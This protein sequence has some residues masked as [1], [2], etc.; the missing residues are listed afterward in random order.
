MRLLHSASRTH[1][2]FDD[3]SLVSC[4]GLVPVM[5]LAQSCGLHELL[6]GLVR[7][8]TSVGS[9][10]AGKI[11]SIVAIQ[12]RVRGSSAGC[13]CSRAHWRHGT[14]GER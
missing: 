2:H 3:P 7:L 8:G 11:T 13:R 6:A 12:P 4:A 14:G 5:G 9:N 10:P 1:A